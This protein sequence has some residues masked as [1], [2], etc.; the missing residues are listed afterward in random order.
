MMRATLVALS[1]AG[2][3][4]LPGCM[5]NRRI[6]DFVAHSSYN[7]YKVTTTSVY[8][9]FLTAWDENDAW[10]CQKAGDT[11]RCTKIVYDASKSGVGGAAPPAAVPPAAAPP[12][13]PAPPAP[14]AAR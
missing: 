3:V 8:Y 2:L 1:L 10:T 6:T 11:F 9:A 13:T 14:G 5:V 7:N 12:A 4:T